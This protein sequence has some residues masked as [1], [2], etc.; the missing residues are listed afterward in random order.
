MISRDILEKNSEYV[1]EIE[2]TTIKG[3]GVVKTFEKVLFVIGAV[4]Y[5]KVKVRVIKVYKS[6]A[7]AKII[8]IIIPSKYRIEPKCK[9]YLKCGGC[10]LMHIKYD[11]QLKIKENQIKENLIRIG[12]VETKVI[13]GTWKGITGAKQQER[14]RNKTIYPVKTGENG[15]IQIGFYKKRTHEIIESNCLVGQEIDEKIKRI[16][17]RWITENNILT[18]DENSGRGLLRHIIIRHSN[19][20]K[21]LNIIL[22]LNQ[23]E[24]EFVEKIKSL[25]LELKKEKEIEK[26]ISGLFI[27]VNNEMNNVIMNSKCERVWAIDKEHENGFKDNVGNIEYIIPPESFYQINAYFICPKGIPSRKFV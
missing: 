7:I 18:Y 6:Y 26:R 9:A 24:K 15:E 16:I 13:E 1:V 11:Y 2:N 12:K 8:E 19:N 23:K 10:D 25:L 21:E 5:D 20:L 17:K 4:K 14:Y 22:V 3:Q 27:S